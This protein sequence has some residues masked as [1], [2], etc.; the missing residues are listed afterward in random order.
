MGMIADT[1]GE[2]W[3]QRLLL[4]RIPAFSFIDLKTDQDGTVYKTF[5][6]CA[7]ARGY[8]TDE[9]ESTR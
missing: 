7:L 4:L 5:Q 1:A 6:E 3:F 9:L 8:V 2:L